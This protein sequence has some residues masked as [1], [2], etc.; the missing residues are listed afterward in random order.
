[1]IRI[2]ILIST[3]SP[4]LVHFNHIPPPTFLVT[5]TA[6]CGHQHPLPCTSSIHRHFHRRLPGPL[7]N[8]ILHL[9]VFSVFII[10]FYQIG[11][12]QIVGGLNLT[13]PSLLLILFRGFKP[14][15]LHLLFTQ[16]PHKTTGTIS[17]PPG[18]PCLC[19]YR[20]WWT[21]T[22]RARR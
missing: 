6:R 10:T 12:V 22:M 15:H 17:P 4:I 16:I 2:S 14:F 19:C 11:V 13:P 20:H 3:R 7:L 8:T 9:V 5:N 18:L 21:R 1:M